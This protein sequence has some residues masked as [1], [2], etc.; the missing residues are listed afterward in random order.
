MTFEEFRAF[1]LSL[2]E[3]VE[4]Q[5][6]GSPDFRVRNKIMANLDETAGCITVKLSLSDQ[7]ALVQRGD[8]SFSLPG[9]WSKFGWTT[10][11]LRTAAPDEI[12]ELIVDSWRRVA[13]REL[14]KQL[15]EHEVMDL[16]DDHPARP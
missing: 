11:D 8:G 5:H 15:A 14:W 13:P 4:A 2:P 16:S 12:K 1:V 10:I 6:H 9:G 3:T 7:Q